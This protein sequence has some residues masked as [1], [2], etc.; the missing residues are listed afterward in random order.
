MTARAR[1]SDKLHSI[2]V[3]ALSPNNPVISPSTFFESFGATESLISGFF[4]FVAGVCN[5][6]LVL[7]MLVEESR[8]EDVL[9]AAP[10]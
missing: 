3:N 9:L 6:L 7:S 4:F 10:R 8:K 2:T 5:V 1:A